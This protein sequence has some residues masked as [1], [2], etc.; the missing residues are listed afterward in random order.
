MSMEND[1]GLILTGEN[2]FQCHFFTINRTWIDPG[3]N[4]GFR[5]ERPA[6][7]HLGHG[8]TRCT[9]V[10]RFPLLFQANKFTIRKKKF[11]DM[12]MT[13]FWMVRTA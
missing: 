1:R 2:L 10:L 7:N 4:P 9:G 6:T 5:G 8:T 12:R 13:A 3:A 11:S